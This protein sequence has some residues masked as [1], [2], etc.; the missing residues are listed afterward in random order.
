MMP[1]R[2]MLTERDGLYAANPAQSTLMP[3]CANSIAHLLPACIGMHVAEARLQLKIAEHR[4]SM[5]K[6]EEFIDRDMEFH[7]AIADISCNPIFPA[8]VESMFRW[9]REYYQTMVRAPGAEELTLS[10][11]QRIVDA[12]AKHEADTAAE[13]MRSHLIRANELYSRLGQT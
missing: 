3:N 10:E 11:H 9:A 13:T 2:H 8:I 6:L 4:A 5:A 1:L 12:I 7:R